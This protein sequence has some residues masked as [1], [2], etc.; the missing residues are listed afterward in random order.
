MIA[1]VSAEASCDSTSHCSIRR[2]MLP[3]QA[4]QRPVAVAPVAALVLALLL[5][6]RRRSHSPP[7]LDDSVRFHGSSDFRWEDLAAQVEALVRP[8]A[9]FEAQ[10]SAVESLTADQIER[11][12][13]HFLRHADAPTPFFKERRSLLQEFPRLC[14]KPL[15][16]LEVGCGNGSAALAVLRGNWFAR[17][18]ATDPSPAA[19]EQTRAALAEAGLR[20]RLSSE[21]QPTPTVPCTEGHGPF[22]VVMIL[23][24]LSAIPGEDDVALLSEAAARLRP[25]GAVLVR[26]YGLYDMRQRKDAQKARLLRASPPEYLRPGGMHRRYYSLERIDEMAAAAG[27]VVEESR[28]LC[29]RLRNEK[30]NLNM[31]R[32]Y[33]H[34]VLARP[35]QIVLKAV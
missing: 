10:N 31:D 3:V 8:P 17:V 24:T 32:V 12:Q 6:R 19:V 5:I 21:V 16:V 15:H 18:H 20:W 23:F 4:S 30:R 14:S 34:A 22:D 9:D 13:L 29:V 1:E 2:D 33:V 26:D 28:Y 7:P 11:W 35:N 27:L 25:G